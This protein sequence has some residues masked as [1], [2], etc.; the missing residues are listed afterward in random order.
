MYYFLSLRDVGLASVPNIKGML[1][2]EE[3]RYSL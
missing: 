3:T 2:L 1:G